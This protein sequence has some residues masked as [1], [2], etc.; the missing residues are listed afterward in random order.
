MIALSIQD[1]TKKNVHFN[2]P[3]HEKDYSRESSVAQRYGCLGDESKI[4]KEPK[5]DGALRHQDYPVAEKVVSSKRHRGLTPI[6][7][8]SQTRH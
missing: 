1:V 7:G 2:G 6:S 8:D 4:R 3:D 5:E